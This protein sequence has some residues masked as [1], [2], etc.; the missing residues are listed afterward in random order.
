[1]EYPHIRLSGTPWERGRQYGEAARDRILVSKAGYQAAFQF[2]AGL[3]WDAAVDA[4]AVY[5]EPI[6]AAFPGYLE[7]MRGI[8]EGSGLSL[9]DILTLNARTE[10]IGAMSAAKAAGPA[11]ECSSFA[12]LGTRTESGHTLLGQ[13]WDWLVH[14]FGSLVVLEVEQDDQPNFV[15]IVEAGLLAKTGM[16]SSGLGVTPNAMVTA[17]DRGAAG[18][19]FHVTLRALMDCDTLADAISLM[20][21]YEHASSANYLLAHADGLAAD[22][23]VAPGRYR[24]TQPILPV[25]GSLVHTNHFL[26]PPSGTRDMSVGAMPDS[27]IRLQSI[28]ASIAESDQRLSLGS[29]RDALADHTGF[30]SSVCCHPDPREADGEQW[31][32]VMSI[33][34]DLD[35][36]A[37]YLT[38]GSPCR[39]DY[40]ELQVG[41]LL[42][43]PGL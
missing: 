14:S 9:S 18:L 23:E 17:A 19:P 37:I 8:A 1:M 32:T 15:T 25:N 4:A 38:Y 42:G 35:A 3:A 33:I 36:R 34:M 39:Q 28:H 16:N 29:L 24:G 21:R 31:A 30:P 13:N 43:R 41:D 40:R 7:E 5:E 10:I 12:L 27:L 20:Q 22:L 26:E 2:M 6:Q 11:R